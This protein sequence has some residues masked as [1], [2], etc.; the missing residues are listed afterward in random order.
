[1]RVAECPGWED[2][3]TCL[4]KS[5]LNVERDERLVLDDEDRAASRAGAPH[6]ASPQR[7]HHRYETTLHATPLDIIASSRMD[8][9]PVVAV[10]VMASVLREVEHRGSLRLV[11]ARRHQLNG[12][13]V[14]R[15][16]PS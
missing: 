6:R 9:V 5:L 7:S 13:V 8:P 4:C 15:S 1:M 14:L 10:G 12:D 3:C 11:A 16:I 2:D